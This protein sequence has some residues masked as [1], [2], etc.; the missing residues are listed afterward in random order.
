MYDDSLRPLTD[1]EFAALPRLS[2]GDIVDL[3]AHFP[4][5]TDEQRLELT[6]DDAARVED[7]DLELNEIFSDAL[8]EY[9]ICAKIAARWDRF[10]FGEAA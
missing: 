3:A 2:N 8:V 5:L 10:G 7:W 4:A 6:P 9:G 1:D